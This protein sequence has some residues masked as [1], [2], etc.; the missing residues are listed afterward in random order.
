LYIEE[1][2]SLIGDGARKPD[3]HAAKDPAMNSNQSFECNSPDVVFESFDDEVVL[4]NLQTGRYYS[5]DP[6]GMMYWEYL[7]QGVPPA[8]IV[9]HVARK[10][11]A[12]GNAS[13]LKLDLEALLSEFQS[14]QLVRTSVNSRSIA[15][16][17]EPKTK[18][19]EKYARPVLS[20]FDDVAEMLLLDPVHDVSEAGWPNPA[21]AEPKQG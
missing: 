17:G 19:P 1:T 6:I 15:E 5:L 11:P 3:F 16:V 4:L 13:E 18:L 12:H 10:F 21:P 7:S 14:E 8:E 9:A 20:K 2:I